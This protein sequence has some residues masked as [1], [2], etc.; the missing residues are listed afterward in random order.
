M[1]SPEVCHDGRLASLFQ[2]APEEFQA[3]RSWSVLSC[4]VL[5]IPLVQVF[6]RTLDAMSCACFEQSCAL[7]CLEIDAATKTTVEC[8][9]QVLHLFPVLT[10]F[11]FNGRHICIN[12]FDRCCEEVLNLGQR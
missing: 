3:G 5:A 2:C 8:R 4:P 12:L 1:P 9:L 11:L 6:M 10:Q 7:L